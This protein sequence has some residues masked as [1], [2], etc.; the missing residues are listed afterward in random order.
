M[1]LDKEFDKYALN[2]SNILVNNQVKDILK[3]AAAKNREMQ[4]KTQ[5]AENI[6]ANKIGNFNKISFY[7]GNFTFEEEEKEGKRVISLNSNEIKELFAR[8]PQ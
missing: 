8:K 2:F 6:L 4:A 5:V 3:K 1:L 7:N